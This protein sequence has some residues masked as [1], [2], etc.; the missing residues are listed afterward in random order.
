[1]ESL[2]Q[3]MHSMPL[4]ARATTTALSSIRAMPIGW[5]SRCTAL[6]C[7]PPSALC[8]RSTLFLVGGA[9]GVAT[10]GEPPLVYALQ[11][12]FVRRIA[13]PPKGFRE[14]QCHRLT[15]RE[16]ELDGGGPVRVDVVDDG[17]HLRPRNPASAPALDDRGLRC[18]VNAEGLHNEPQ[19]DSEATENQPRQ[20]EPGLA[21]CKGLGAQGQPARCARESPFPRKEH[22]TN[23]D[24]GSNCTLLDGHRNLVLCLSP[25]IG[26][27]MPL[28][29]AL[30]VEP[31]HAGHS[32]H[33]PAV[34][35]VLNCRWSRVRSCRCED[36][37]S[38]GL[39]GAAVLALTGTY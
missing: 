21:V 9:P 15:V 35:I 25:L 6:G 26:T 32:R 4:V 18:Q 33:F 11:V 17:L 30:R 39:R 36:A 13:L 27:S 31:I 19:H 29:P 24:C 16:Y 22:R 10:V 38:S 2:S 37:C 5:P 1:M 12:P 28:Q 3:R 20:C 23:P 14:G 34:S 8:W 7:Q